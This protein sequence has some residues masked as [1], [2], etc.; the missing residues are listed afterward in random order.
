[1]ISSIRSVV[2]K[3][4]PTA[5]V[6]A[7]KDQTGSP[8]MAVSLHRLRLKGFSPRY[9]VDI[10]AYMGWWTETAHS[11]FPKAEILMVEPL[12]GHSDHLRRLAAKLKARYVNEVC[13]AREGESFPFYLGSIGSSIYAP[14]RFAASEVIQLSTTTLDA[15]VERMGWPEAN[16]VKID[17]QGA[18]EDVLDGA[19][20]VLEKAEVVIMELSI[21]KSYSKGL[22]AGDM[23]SL[24]QHNGFMLYDIAG[25]NRANRTRSVNEFDAVFVKSSSSLWDINY[26]L[27]VGAPDQQ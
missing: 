4:A 20:N 8:D 23:I 12:P 26:F 21:V 13:A 9:I 3:L 17:V 18:E 16:L 7:I 1:M 11:K 25:L 15:L 19:K 27:P 22:L 10:G 2:R 24:M 6:S 14:K 5:L